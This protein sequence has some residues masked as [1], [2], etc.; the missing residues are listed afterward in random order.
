MEKSEERYSLMNFWKNLRT[1]RRTLNS[2]DG[3]LRSIR[4]VLSSVQLVRCSSC[5][6]QYEI[7]PAEYT[8]VDFSRNHAS[9]ETR[10]ECRRRLRLSLFLTPILSVFL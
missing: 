4:K 7:N 10:L 9:R 5:G 8:Q 6:A 1:D 2:V 3:S